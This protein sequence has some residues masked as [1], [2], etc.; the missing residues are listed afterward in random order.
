MKIKLLFHA[1]FSLLVLCAS[2][3]AQQTFKPAGKEQGWTYNNIAELHDLAKRHLATLD[4][5]IA[6]KKAASE[7]TMNPFKSTAKVN[8]D[9]L[10]KERKDFL[11]QEWNCPY[12]YWQKCG[13]CDGTGA[14]WLGFKICSDCK[15]TKGSNLHGDHSGADKVHSCNPSTIRAL[16]K[17]PD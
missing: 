3:N 14:I 17:A 12:W 9:K 5:Q 6:D 10:A 16:L 15:G 2:S 4:T 1:C 13:K 11:D 7:A 8:Y